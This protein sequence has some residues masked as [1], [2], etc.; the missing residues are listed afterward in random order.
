VG[1]GVLGAAVSVRGSTRRTLTSLFVVWTA[2]NIVFYLF[3]LRSATTF[4]ARPHWS[5]R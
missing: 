5:S 2:A 4:C 3:R 1:V